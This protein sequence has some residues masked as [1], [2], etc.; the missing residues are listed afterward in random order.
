MTISAD[1]MNQYQTII[2]EFKLNKANSKLNKQVWLKSH[3]HEAGELLGKLRQFCSSAKV[4]R[5]HLKL[6]YY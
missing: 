6:V 3:M 5:L 1:V 2:D 4:S